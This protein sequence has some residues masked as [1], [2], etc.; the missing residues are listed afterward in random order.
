M[1]RASLIRIRSIAF[2]TV[3]VSSIAGVHG[4]ASPASNGAH[5]KK[6]DAFLRRA[7]DEDASDS[8]SQRVIVRVEP[9]SVAAV[10]AFLKDRGDKV[11]RFH[12]GIVAFTTE[13][14]HLVQLAS[15]P[16]IKSIS[17]D[18]ALGA[19]QTTTLPTDKVVRDS[20]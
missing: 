6:L 16:G 3:L 1:T 7:L 12:R 14:K 18:A 17:V 9:D 19:H 5:R 4:A 15:H 8:T 20:V 10:R 2:V 13:S 11:I